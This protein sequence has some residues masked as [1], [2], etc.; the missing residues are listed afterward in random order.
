MNDDAIVTDG[1]MIRRAAPG[2]LAALVRLVAEYCEPTGTRSTSGSRSAGRS[3]AARIRHVRCGARCGGARV[4]RWRSRRLCGRHVGLVGGDRRRARRCWTSCSPRRRNRGIGSRADR[5]HRGRVSTAG[6]PSSLPRTRTT[7]RGCAPLVPA[8]R[9]RR[10]DIDLD[11][12]VA[13]VRMGQAPGRVRCR[14]RSVDRECHG[15]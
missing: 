7:E 1:S 4:E 10:R 8:P 5:A 2:D 14:H 9:L 13:G 11:G 6:C 3:P 12:E 15:T